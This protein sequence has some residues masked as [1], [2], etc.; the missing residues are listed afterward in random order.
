MALT[1]RDRKVLAEIHEWEQNLLQ[2]EPNDFQLTYEKYLERSFSALPIKIQ[3]Q[4][5]SLLDTWLFHLHSMIQGS[6]LQLD[7]KKRI[8]AQGRI[9]DKGLNNIEDLRKLE[10]EKLEYIADQQI[11]RHRLYSFIQGG[12][13][14]T[15]GALALGTDIPAMAM[16]NL[17]AVQLISFAYGFEVNTPYEIIQSLKVFHTATLPLRLQKEGWL[18]LTED[19][20]VGE[21]PY[22]Y[23]GNDEMTDVTWIEQPARQLLKAFVISIFRKKLIQGIPIISM[24]IG[25]GVNYHLTRRVT[26]MA[27]KYYQLRY[28]KEKEAIF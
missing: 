17:R 9:F 11:A 20:K 26:E 3:R 13:S 22:F 24:T 16:I 18:S 1:E 23:E 6:E 14:G 25:A 15:G 8:L 21:N 12:L 5:F 28:L 4:F 10:I 27:Q 19:L 2:Y 7:V